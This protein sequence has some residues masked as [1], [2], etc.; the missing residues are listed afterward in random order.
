MGRLSVKDH[1][2]IRGAR[3]HNLRSLDLDLP[4]DRIIAL[5]GV[6]G[7]GKSSL[8]CDTL[9]AEARRRFLLTAEGPAAAFARRLQPPRV[10]RI[11]GLR[12]ALAIAQARSRPSS[13]STTAT[14]TGL[15]DYLRLLWARVGR[16]HCLDCGEPVAA[17]PFDEILE[18]ASG[19]PGAA[20]W[21]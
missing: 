15:S 20:D 1:L 14:I 3:E 6:S 17:H 11:D 4:H 16:A 10:Q 5:T 19:G 9:Y 7:S 13:R 2:E 8:A 18:R 21:W 12:P